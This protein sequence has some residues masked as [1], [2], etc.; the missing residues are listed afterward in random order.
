MAAGLTVYDDNPEPIE[1]KRYGELVFEY[2]GW[3]HEVMMT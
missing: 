1:D 2:Y 3:G